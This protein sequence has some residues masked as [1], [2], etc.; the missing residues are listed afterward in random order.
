MQQKRPAG[1]RQAFSC[2]AHE[3]SGPA[4]GCG[5]QQIKLRYQGAKQKAHR[6]AATQTARSK[7]GQK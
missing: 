4:Q 5:Q 6:G 7:L 3:S 2:L 1:D